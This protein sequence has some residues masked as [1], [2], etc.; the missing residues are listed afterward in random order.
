MNY[1]D[2]VVLI[3]YRYI[4]DVHKLREFVCTLKKIINLI[5]FAIEIIC[6]KDLKE[7]NRYFSGFI[8]ILCKFPHVLNH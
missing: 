4:L 2:A 8:E 1:I 6:E 5:V 7:E 3:E